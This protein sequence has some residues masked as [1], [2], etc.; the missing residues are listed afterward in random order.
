MDGDD[1]A[2]EQAREQ[3][4]AQAR[5]AEDRQRFAIR[6]EEEAMEAEEHQLE[7]ELD[8][9]G[10]D[11][12]RTERAIEHDLSEGHWGNDP[13]PPMSW[14]GG[15]GEEPPEDERPTRERDGR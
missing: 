12:A 5:D 2:R 13:G 7:R 15:P 4:H 10:A 3:A 1:R 6:R 9:L 14:R 8:D 11:L